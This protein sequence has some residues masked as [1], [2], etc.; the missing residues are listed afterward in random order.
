MEHCK[1]DPKDTKA[2]KLKVPCNKIHEEI[3]STIKVLEYRTKQCEDPKLSK[4]YETSVKYEYEQ[5]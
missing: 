5:A 1:C 2:S 3:R 4:K